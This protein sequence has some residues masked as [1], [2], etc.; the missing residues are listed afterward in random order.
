MCLRVT[1]CENRTH[2][3]LIMTFGHTLR[4]LP[5]LATVLL[6]LTYKL[7]NL[8]I[9]ANTVRT[10]KKTSVLLIITCDYA[11]DR[12]S[13]PP[14]LPPCPTSA[15][16]LLVSHYDV[17][18]AECSKSTKPVSG[19]VLAQRFTDKLE[20]NTSNNCCSVNPRRR[21]LRL[22]R[23]SNFLETFVY[24]VFHLTAYIRQST[25]IAVLAGYSNTLF[26][27]RC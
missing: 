23:C 22:H 8:P 10:T 1:D 12:R 11:Q 25:V 24:V 20:S 21:I 2:G 9:I 7:Y 17:D 6:I 4:P 5:I 26:I 15:R 13:R 14:A 16:S 18:F 27:N 3:S 19:F